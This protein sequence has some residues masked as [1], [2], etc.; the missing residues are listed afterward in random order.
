MRRDED[1]A[2]TLRPLELGVRV[3]LA[4]GGAQGVDAGVSGD[5]DL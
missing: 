2:G 4:H 3:P 1:E 5:P